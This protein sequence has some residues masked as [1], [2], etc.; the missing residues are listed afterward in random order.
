MSV[1]RVISLLLVLAAPFAAAEN[2]PRKPRSNVVKAN[3]SPEQVNAWLRAD[4]TCHFFNAESPSVEDGKVKENER[5]VIV[6]DS[7]DLLR[8]CQ[9]MRWHLGRHGCPNIE[10]AGHSNYQSLTMG[11]I[12]GI[13]VRP[14]SISVYPSDDG[15]FIKVASCLRDLGAPDATIVY[16]TCG[17]MRENG[18]GSRIIQYPGKRESH[19]ALSNALQFPIASCIGPCGADGPGTYSPAG[20]YISYPQLPDEGN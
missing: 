17:G 14:G 19:A 11:E 9:E 13:D 18:D 12:I 1:S 3:I 7:R 15:L 16:S 10:F 8:K 5:Q 4:S 20:W 2:P 6:K